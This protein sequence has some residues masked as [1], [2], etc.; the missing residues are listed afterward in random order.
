MEIYLKD[1][2]Q[3]YY[4]SDKEDFITEVG[5]EA[6]ELGFCIDA[7][8]FEEAVKIAREELNWIVTITEESFND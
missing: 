2:G 6:Y 8:N 3:V 4:Y 1:N 7:D 5:A